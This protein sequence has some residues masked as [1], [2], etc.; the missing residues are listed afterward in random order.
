MRSMKTMTNSWSRS[1]AL[2]PT[3]QT[4]NPANPD[5]ATYFDVGQTAI[6]VDI[7][8]EFGGKPKLRV[9][10]TFGGAGSWAIGTRHGIHHDQ[11][12]RYLG[13]GVVVGIVNFSDKTWSGTVP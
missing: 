9:L 7:N 5:K 13:A 10:T 4:I 11:T 1:A 2:L 3:G 8:E 12:G 6:V